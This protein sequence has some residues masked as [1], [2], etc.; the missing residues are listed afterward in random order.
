MGGPQKIPSID[1]SIAMSAVIRFSPDLRDW[2]VKNLDQG[3]APAALI[4]TMIAQRMEPGAARSIVQAFVSA[5]Q[6]R[7][8]M[9]VD[10]VPLAEPESSLEPQ[11]PRL[12][13]G[14]VLKT[15]DREIR[16]LARLRQPVLAVLSDVMS[17]EECKELIELARPRLKPSTIVDLESG[18]DVV[19]AYRNSLGMFFRL[20]ETAFIARLDRR[21]SELMNLP[22]E[23]GEGLQVLHYPTGAASAP[24]VDF[25][26]ITNEAN[27]S[28][29]AR[30]GQRVSTLVTYLNDVPAGGET[31]F[32]ELRLA[33]TPRLGHAAYFEY[34]DNRGF[35]DW[36]SLHAGNPVLEGEKWVAS[37]WMR[38]RE[39][40]M[41]G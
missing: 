37:K 22:V 39:F 10:S 2:L 5:I 3:C 29:I 17:A 14:P 31:S 30:S 13:G 28:S 15:H 40:V 12:K 8:P 34:Y 1:R 11:P 9:P 19:A 41:G 32:P 23:N 38:Q 4:E 16:V 33:V 7:R 6:A 26:Q 25:L 20:R 24:H 36:R 35:V 18:Q 27:R 21:I